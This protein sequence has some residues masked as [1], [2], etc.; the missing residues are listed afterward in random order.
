[1]SGVP[2]PFIYLTLKLMSRSFLWLGDEKTFSNS[3]L[4]LYFDITCL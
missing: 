3:H 2:V 4:K 1:M